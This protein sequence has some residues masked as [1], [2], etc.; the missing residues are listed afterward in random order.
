MHIT[1]AEWEVMQAVWDGGEQVAG[2]VIARIQNADA[3]KDDAARSRQWSHRT[4]R[5]LLGRLVDKAAIAVRVD[6]RTHFYR[7]AVSKDA[8]VRSAAK[9]F[10]QRFFSGDV[11]SLLMHF[12]QHES[13][14]PDDW[15]A[16]REAL[17]SPK[18]SSKHRKG[19]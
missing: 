13:I 10:S 14:S 12:A 15:A 16:I 4:I 1:E 19:E 2:D 3:A 8:C 6:G 7:A 9:S 5:T 17:D 18:S 11:K